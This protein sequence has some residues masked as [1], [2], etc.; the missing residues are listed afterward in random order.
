MLHRRPVGIHVYVQ[1]CSRQ[2]NKGRQPRC[3]ADLAHVRKGVKANSTDAPNP[4]PSPFLPSGRPAA[5]PPSPPRTN[6][7]EAV[8]EEARVATEPRT[9]QPRGILAG[10]RR[11]ARRQGPWCPG[12][13]GTAAGGRDAL[14]VLFAGSIGQGR[15]RGGECI[16]SYPPASARQSMAESQGVGKVFAAC[17]R[18]AAPPWSDWSRMVDAPGCA[19]AI[20]NSQS[21][22]LVVECSFATAT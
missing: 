3:T 14:R 20:Y 18:L 9:R 7:D 2:V 1:T 10:C 17:A 4:S 11:G 15:E 8:R 22:S 16:R 21:Q 5:P 6:G 12:T 13:C 19:D